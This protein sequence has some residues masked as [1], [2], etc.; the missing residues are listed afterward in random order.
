MWCCRWEDAPPPAIIRRAS[1]DEQDLA[2]GLRLE[3]QRALDKRGFDANIYQAQ[4]NLSI[5]RE[6]AP[7]GA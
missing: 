7:Q 6:D 1:I 2:G 4:L 5:A 3:Y